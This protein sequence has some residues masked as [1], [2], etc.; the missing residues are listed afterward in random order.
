MLLLP[1][2]DLRIPFFW[3]DLKVLLE[4]KGGLLSLRLL[5]NVFLWLQILILILCDRL[6]L[7]FFGR[8]SRL[9][10]EDELAIVV[11]V[12]VLVLVICKILLDERLLLLEGYWR[13]N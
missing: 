7:Q 12:A 11:M 8:L 4:L 9:T 5:L 1:K 13:R 3:T 6:L 10:A 2:R